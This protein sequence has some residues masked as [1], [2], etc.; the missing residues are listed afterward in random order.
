MADADLILHNARIATLDSGRPEATAVAVRD[1]R[2]IGC[3]K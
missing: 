2:F 1:G 3:R